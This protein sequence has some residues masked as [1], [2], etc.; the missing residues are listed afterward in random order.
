MHRRRALRVAGTA[1]AAVLGGTLALAAN[2]GLLGFARS[3]APSLGLLDATRATADQAPSEP[4]VVTRYEDI[5]V[6]APPAPAP[7][8]TPPAPSAPAASGTGAE[9]ATTSDSVELHVE[10]EHHDDEDDHVEDAEDHED[11]EDVEEHE[12]EDVTEGLRDDD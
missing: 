8:A 6:P 7:A 9:A 3:D 12:A 4:R 5:F 1:T 11:I 10:D 2:F